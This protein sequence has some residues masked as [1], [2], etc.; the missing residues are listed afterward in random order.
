MNQSSST[1]SMPRS[2]AFSRFDVLCLPPL[3]TT[4]WV[5]LRVRELE[6]VPPKRE[7]ASSATRRTQ[8][9]V[10]VMQIT[11]PLNGCEE[12]SFASAL[13]PHTSCFPRLAALASPP[14][15][16]RSPRLRFTVSTF[17]V[18]SIETAR[19]TLFLCPSLAMPISLRSSEVRALRPHP[20]K[21]CSFRSTNVSGLIWH[22]P[23]TLS[24]QPIAIF[25]SQESTFDMSNFATE[26]LDDEFPFAIFLATIS[27]D[28]R[29]EEE[30]IAVDILPDDEAFSTLTTI[31]SSSS[32]ASSS[33]G[34]S[35]S[36]ARIGIRSAASKVSSLSTARSTFPSERRIAS[37]HSAFAKPML[38]KWSIFERLAWRRK[39]RRGGGETKPASAPF[40]SLATFVAPSFTFSSTTS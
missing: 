13:I 29:E 39:V 37:S 4:R 2:R 30:E 19:R 1:I 10:P 23:Y 31:G 14:P 27:D 38:F 16:P 12:L 17:G 5:T 8:G 9:R 22:C 28:G 20:V 34:S 40:S 11:M 7:I 24:S 3:A 25:S 32:E 26:E 36:A 6:K 35:S 33:I 15:S 21:S 18:F